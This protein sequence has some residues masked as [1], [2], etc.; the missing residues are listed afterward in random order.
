ME[1]T[2][3]P[4]EKRSWLLP[5]VAVL[6]V[7]VLIANIVI[8]VNLS[9]PPVKTQTIENMFVDINGDK[10]VD[11]LVKGEIILNTDETLN[12]LMSQSKQK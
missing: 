12:L 11:Y 4:V 6:F 3:E 2:K 9:S 5:V 7:M 8:Y 10:K 1:K